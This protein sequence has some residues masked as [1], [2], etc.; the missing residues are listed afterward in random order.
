MRLVEE[1]VVDCDVIGGEVVVDC[2]MIGG[3]VVVD[4]DDVIGGRN[5]GRL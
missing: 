5:G 2:D 4:C 1:V 3:E